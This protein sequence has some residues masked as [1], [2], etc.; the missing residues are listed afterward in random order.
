MIIIPDIHGRQFWKDAV[1]GRESEEIVFL[2]DYLDPYPTE[3]ITNDDALKNFKEILDFKKKHR[4]NVILLVGNHDAH[5]F[6]SP[7]DIGSRFCYYLEREISRLFKENKELFLLAHEKEIN[8]KK[9]TFSHSYIHS[10]WLN[11]DVY[12]KDNWSEDTVINALNDDFEHNA[13]FGLLLNIKSCYRGG[14][15]SYGSI[16][17]A[18]IREVALDKKPNV[19][20]YAIFGHTQL[21]F[22]IVTDYV[23]CLDCRRAFI[24]TDSGE[25]QGIDGEPIE[26]TNN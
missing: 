13:T 6:V 19:G 21:K 23:A 14:F 24:L 9:Y 3:D 5:Y 18:D 12:G 4:E 25:I 15:E 26:K 2:G 20:D 16:L 22:P 10:L 1:S 8:S 7:F 17:W 11:N